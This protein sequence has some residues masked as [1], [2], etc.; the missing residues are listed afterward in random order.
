MNSRKYWAITAALGCMTL[1]LAAML[2]FIAVVLVPTQIGMAAH[3]ILSGQPLASPTPVASNDASLPTPSAAV[4]AGQ[5]GSLVTLYKQLSPGIVNIDVSMGQGALAG[6]GEGSGFIYDD[7]GHIITNNHVVDQANHVT[8]VFYNGIEAD[9]TI[10]GTDP[11]SDLAVLKVDKLPAG[12]HPLTLGNSDQVAVGESVIAI[13]N[14][15]GLGSSMTAG[16]VSAVGRT[17]ESGATPFSI[18][19]AIQTDAA[20]NPGNSGGPLLNLQ[21][22]VVGVN[23]QIATN[24]SQA[25]AGV[26]FAI[27]VNIV[28]QVVPVLL[29]KGSY[30]WPW[31]GVSGGSVDLAV[32]KAN[33][34][35]NQR[36]AYIDEV[37]RGGP[38]AKA[39]LQGSTGSQIVDG[40]Q[41]PTGGDVIVAIDGKP[42]DNFDTLLVQIASHKPG[43]QVKLTVLHDGTSRQITVTL[44]G[45]PSQDQMV[46]S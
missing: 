34:L 21:G 22:Q 7:Q 32:M 31:L 42:V 46:S 19:Q 17:I 30:Q 37:T 16:I 10:V 23:A 14:P 39:G 36:G 11:Y 15:F 26:G 6:Q 45:R 35:P 43:D 33:N 40:V 13:G 2:V 27:P 12:T 5:Q 20:I 9:A 4:P 8:V 3:G 1:L 25:S 41:V 28:R 29:Q 44:E 24:G 18:P 38:A